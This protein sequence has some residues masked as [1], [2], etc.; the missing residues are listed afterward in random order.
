[1]ENTKINR[2][3]KPTIEDPIHRRILALPEWLKNP[4]PVELPFSGLHTP[5]LGFEDFSILAR[6]KDFYRL[7][8]GL[9]L[10]SIPLCIIRIH[11]E[12]KILLQ[13]FQLNQF[14]EFWNGKHVLQRTPL[15]KRE[16]QHGIH[17]LWL[18]PFPRVMTCKNEDGLH[19]EIFRDGKTLVVRHRKEKG[20]NVT[21]SES[22][23]TQK[24]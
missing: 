15:E 2:P 6:V 3:K 23:F 24:Y 8:I 11:A 9:K 1:M 5:V 17:T 12:E 16:F 4:I 18:D 7:E 10:S 21:I 13:P 20:G 22:D 14:A 19:L